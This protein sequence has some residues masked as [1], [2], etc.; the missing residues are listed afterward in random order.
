MTINASADTQLGNKRHPKTQCHADAVG[1]SVTSSGSMQ[2]VK[3]LTTAG[4]SVPHGIDMSYYFR[5]TRHRL[6]DGQPQA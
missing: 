3:V 5:Q 1:E 6:Q 4:V 2:G